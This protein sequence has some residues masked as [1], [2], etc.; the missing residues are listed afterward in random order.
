MKF[1]TPKNISSSK[2]NN[3]ISPKIKFITNNSNNHTVIST[4]R[5]NRD[6]TILIESPCAT[7]YGEPD[8]DRGLQTIQKYMLLENEPFIQSLYPRS[9]ISNYPRTKMI[10]Q[11]H[12]IIASLPDKHNKLRAFF[13]T[14]AKNEIEFYYAKYLFNAFEGYSYGPLTLP[15]LAKF[16][17][18]CKSN[19]NFKFDVSRGVMIVQSTREI[20]PGEELFNS[21]LYN[22]TI[23]NHREYLREHY[24]FLCD[25]NYNK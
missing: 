3:Y 1:Q 11:I 23:P 8:I 12:K 13:E 16:N 18:S 20:L 24:G 25:C 19:I 22:K 10:K 21:Y 15:L 6:E 4:S 17:H 9:N 2:T 14:Y 5:I 7:L